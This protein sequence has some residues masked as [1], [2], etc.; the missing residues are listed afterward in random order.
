[1]P[2]GT[3]T[4]GELS[5]TTTGYRPA[6]RTAEI[7]HYDARDTSSKPV[8]RRGRRATRDSKL[9]RLEGHK[10]TSSYRLFETLCGTSRRNDVTGADRP[11]PAR[12]ILCHPES[13]LGRNPEVQVEE[14]PPPNPIIHT[15]VA[16]PRKVAQGKRHFGPSAVDAFPPIRSHI[17]KVGIRGV[18][19]VWGAMDTRC[20]HDSGGTRPQ[21]E[22]LSTRR[23]E[24]D[25]RRSAISKRGGVFGRSVVAQSE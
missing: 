24:A 17:R 6:R 8:G 18:C 1:M 16:S 10:T 5:H 13:Y 15:A 19:N 21:H 11:N 3:G 4:G 9:A 2:E 14:L 20:N 25:Q 22:C 23:P 7:R 12:A